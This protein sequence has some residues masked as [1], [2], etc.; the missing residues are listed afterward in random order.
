[1]HCAACEEKVRRIL[2]PFTARVDVSL[3]E[4]RATLAGVTDDL[5]TL[6]AAL[7]T[8]GPYRLL[9]GDAAVQTPAPSVLPETPAQSPGSTYYPLFL[10]VGYLALAA[11][12]GGP[13]AWMR[14]FMAGFFLVF[15]FFKLL[16]LRGFADAYAGYDLLAARVRGY[17]FVYPFLELALGM[18]YLFG[19]APFATS[20]V[21][22]VLMLFGSMGVVNALLQKRKIRCACL[23]TVIKLP[24]STVTL[25][26]DLGMAAMAAAMLW[27]Y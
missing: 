2:A 10:I 19:F 1:M 12:A 26:E 8:V 23:G 20:V 27:P 13:D 18:A 5:E 3:T 14:H 11:F 25:I 7:A 15:S 17:G 21:T 9:P 24:M 4:G 16:D 22:L 6:N